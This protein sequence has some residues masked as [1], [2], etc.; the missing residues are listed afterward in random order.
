MVSGATVRRSLGIRDFYKRLPLVRELHDIRESV[1]RQQGVLQHLFLA[2][3]EQLRSSILAEPRYR[4]PRHLAHFEHRAFSQHG[5]DGILLEILRRIGVTHRYFVEVGAGSGI[6][7]D[8]GILFAQGWRGIW[9]EGDGE[10]VRTIQKYLRPHLDTGDLTVLRTFVTRDNV[11]QTMAAAPKDFDVLVI[12]IDQNT[13]WIWR[14]LQEFRPRVVMVEYNATWPP[15]VSWIA[16]YSPS[17]AW[18]GSFGYGASL[19]SFEELG[20][21]LGYELVACDLSGTNAFF[22]RADLLG[23]HFVGPFDAVTHYQPARYFLRGSS[24]H[25]AGF[26]AFASRP[27]SVQSDGSPSVPDREADHSTARR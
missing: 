1:W 24:G 7:N 13:Y 22:V 4:D 11:A 14:A 17:A 6:E 2:V 12:D 16:P 21:E 23:Q 15:S 5:E 27:L 9:I 10:H 20:R 19:K 18:D 8:T 25:P 3:Q 26:A